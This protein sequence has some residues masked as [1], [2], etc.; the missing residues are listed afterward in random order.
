M[1]KMDSIGR[2]PLRLVQSLV[3]PT[4]GL[5]VM[6]VLAFFLSSSSN[7]FLPTGHILTPARL[8]VL[9]T[10]ILIILTPL[11][12]PH[13]RPVHAPIA[14][15]AQPSAY[16]VFP[17]ARES[18]EPQAVVSPGVPA[19]HRYSSEFVSNLAAVPSRF[20]V[21]A[22]QPG[23]SRRTSLHA[24]APFLDD[25]HSSQK[26]EY[27]DQLAQ[28]ARRLEESFIMPLIVRPLVQELEESDKQLSVIFQHFG[29]KLTQEPS[30]KLDSS[31]VSLSDRYLPAPMSNDAQVANVWQKRQFLEAMLTLP[32]YPRRYRDYIF[33][34]VSAWA[35]R[36]GIRFAYRHD[37]RPDEEGP[38]DSHI[39][40]HVVFS[41][42][43]QLLGLVGFRERYVSCSSRNASGSATTDEFQSL[44]SSVM[45]A[46]KSLG[47]QHHSRV[48][49]L[50]QHSCPLHFNVGTNQRVF[51]IQGGGGNFI[52]ALALFF[53]LLKQLSPVANWLQIPQNIRI[54]I[55]ASVASP[56]LT[57][58]S[59]FSSSLSSLSYEP[60]R[61]F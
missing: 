34:R 60:Y 14:R 36:G 43:D 28:W 61:G 29:V 8:L 19:V 37:L 59:L 20:D 39:L 52:E 33:S 21:G 7:V 24:P 9:L 6:S 45:D 15:V 38:T 30:S 31:Q 18:A 54:A 27:T 35:H 32:N 58:T 41:S 48:V 11:M 12:R 10:I 26:H 1:E 42:F 50:E 25:V 17:E 22:P 49:W 55:E 44:F 40:A 51:G 23:V 46:K 56:S 13:G 57:G 16:S 47:L 5:V 2:S 53:F 3:Y 4:F